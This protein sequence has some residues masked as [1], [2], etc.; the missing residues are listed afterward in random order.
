MKE[1]TI[2]TLELSNN[3]NV[4]IKVLCTTKKSTIM[5]KKIIKNLKIGKK[6]IISNYIKDLK[7]KLKNFDIV[8][9]PAG[10]TTF[11]TIISRSLPVTV[12]IV[13]D[14]RESLETWRSLGHFLHIENKNKRNK[15]ILRSKWQMVF[16]NYDKL[17]Y[18]LVK[19]S[20]QLDGLGASRI[21]KYI[22]HS[23]KNLN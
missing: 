16:K 3:R 1:L 11:E 19:K 9:G 18:D 17:L 22:N 14:G 10:T 8:V 15:K 2:T 13:N 23:K 20:R 5:I 21:F 7:S 12:P 6:I 4:D